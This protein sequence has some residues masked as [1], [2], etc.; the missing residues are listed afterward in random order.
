MGGGATTSYPIF[1]PNTNGATITPT[2]GSVTPVMA[3]GS[4]S[5][6]LQIATSYS[7][8]NVIVRVG[9]DTL[10][11]VNSIYTISN[12]NA[13]RV[14]ELLNL[15]INQYPIIASPSIYGSISPNDT[16]LVNYNSNI[17]YSITPSVGYAILEVF[18]DSISVGAV[19]SYTFT[20]VTEPHFIYATFQTGS[21]DII[22]SSSNNLNFTTTQ[23]VAS[24]SQITVV[25]ADVNQLTIN[26]LVKAPQHFQV[27]LNGTA[28]YSQL[29]IQKSNLPEELYIRFL[30]TIVGQI[31]DTIKVSSYGALT[32]IF[33]SGLSNVGVEDFGIDENDVALYPNPAQ[34]QLSIELSEQM[35]SYPEWKMEIYDMLT[36][37]IQEEILWNSKSNIDVSNLPSGV[38]FVVLTNRSNRIVKKVVVN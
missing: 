18:V 26:I 36:H 16:T 33:V 29:V 38:Y 2:N 25:S 35:S 4:Y 22:Q 14:I 8:S 28:W 32:Y 20:N 12:I 6:T 5:F 30:P 19:S 31:S 7:N 1:I 27:S 17:S 3:G 24:D 37:K 13:P 10:I 9:T 15:N 34:T 23:N 21:P 11:P